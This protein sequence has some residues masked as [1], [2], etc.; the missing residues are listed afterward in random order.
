MGLE[1]EGDNSMYNPLLDIET[2]SDQP[3]PPSL[4]THGFH[5]HHTQSICSP[6]AS[7][8]HHGNHH[9]PLAH[10]QPSLTTMQPPSTTC[11]PTQLHLHH[12]A[13]I[14]HKAHTAHPCSR[15]SHSCTHK[16]HTTHL[17]SHTSSQLTHTDHTTHPCSPQF[18]DAHLTLTCS[19]TC[20]LLTS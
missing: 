5:S 10:P 13:P 1:G 7:Y 18:I 11:S 20:S 4:L 9:P 3:T 14:V 19:P 15:T 16:A 6:H 12:V 17:C 8:G 2:E